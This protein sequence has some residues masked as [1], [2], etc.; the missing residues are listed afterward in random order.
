M[1][2][3]GAKP[4]WLIVIAIALVIVTIPHVVEDFHYGNILGVHLAG[5][6]AIAVL[7]LAYGL[8]IV[9]I[10]LLWPARRA[11]ATLL[12]VTGAAW[13]VGTLVVHGSELLFSGADY[14]HGL[15]SKLLEVLIIAFG[16]TSAWL[17]AREVAR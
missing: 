4:T 2:S 9:G 8:Q 17:G 7:T 6:T 1:R 16:A 12:A 14:R 3:H 11:G 5:P 15:I 10:A 13:C